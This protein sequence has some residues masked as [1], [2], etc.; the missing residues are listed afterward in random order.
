MKTL[1]M[2]DFTMFDMANGIKGL[3]KSKLV[4]VEMMGKSYIVT[5]NGVRARICG[6]PEVKK[7]IKQ[8]CK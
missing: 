7:F 2:K 3:Y 5:A 8:E 6:V 1:T 4:T